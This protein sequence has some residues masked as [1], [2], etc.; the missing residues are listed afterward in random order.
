MADLAK[1]ETVMDSTPVMVTEVTQRS[2]YPSAAAGRSALLE[3]RLSRGKPKFFDSGDYNMNM[4][5]AKPKAPSALSMETKRPSVGTLNLKSRTS[6]GNSSS[7]SS[8]DGSQISPMGKFSP[9]TPPSTPADGGENK[10]NFLS[11][12]AIQKA[13]ENDDQP[14]QQQPG[15]PLDQPLQQP[16]QQSLQPLPQI[17]SAATQIPSSDVRP[18]VR[19]QS[20]QEVSDATKVKTD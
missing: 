17:F 4:A 1:S 10:M 9:Y 6:S 5:H 16:L 19:R 15:Q 12:A 11:V 20:P 2:K 8:P 18:A 7:D 13:L 14:L 3:K